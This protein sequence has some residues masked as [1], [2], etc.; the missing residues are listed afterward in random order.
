M[1]PTTVGWVLADGQ[2]VDGAM[3]AG[4]EFAI[5]RP[6]GGTGAGN[7]SAQVAAAVLRLQDALEMQGRRLHGVGVTW[8]GEA[9]AEAALLLESLS[10]AGFD[11]V[12]PVRFH[13]AAESLADG[14]DAPGASEQ[15]AVCIIEQGSAT[16]VLPDGGDGVPS[17]SERE[18]SGDD[19]LSDWLATF[20]TADSRRPESL[21]VAGSDTE[22]DAVA[23]RLEA[24]LSLPVVAEAEAQLSLARGAALALDPGAALAEAR[25]D[26]APALDRGIGAAPSRPLSYTGA[27]TMLVAGVVTFVV[28]LS[29]TLSLQLTPAKDQPPV[30][31]AANGSAIAASGQTVTP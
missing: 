4:D 10:G 7:V 22:L 9:A 6:A 28:S 15:A 23:A 2:D 21:V 18:F 17:V 27:L 11:N 14:V 20:F 24:R 3:L 8:S 5:R 29:L 30:Q 25:R 26:A 1:T 13:Q 19:E 16:V 31:R 12:V